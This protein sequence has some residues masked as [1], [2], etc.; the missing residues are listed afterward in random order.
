MNKL[1]VLILGSAGMAGHIIKNHLSSFPKKIEVYDV[2][3]SSKYVQP[4]FLFDVTDFSSLNNLIVDLKPDC[5]INCIGILNETAESN[6]DLAILVNSYLPHFLESKTKAGNCKIIH[7]STD[8]VFSGLKGDYVEKDPKDGVGIYAQSKALG[9]IINIKDLTIRTSIIGPELNPDGI[10][11]LHWFLNQKNDITGYSNAFWSGVT[12]NEL[13]KF[14]YFVL[15]ERFNLNGIYHLTNNTKI[16]KCTLLEY[17]Q[18]A[19]KKDEFKI[20]SSDKYK[21][22]KSFINTKNDILFKVSDYN[23]MI[24]EMSDYIRKYKYLYQYDFS[25]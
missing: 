25:V 5:I 1:K 7:I 22:D 13:A 21:I 15:T 20:I 3:R 16:D 2:A 10:G 4:S 24:N 9:E 11:L 12:T 8:C 19:F 23:N 18:S 6:P 17:F 14:I